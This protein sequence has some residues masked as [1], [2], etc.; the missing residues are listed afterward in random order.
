TEIPEEIQISGVISIREHQ[1]T[2]A[3]D[4]RAK[5]YRVRVEINK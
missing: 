2:L 1:T 5:G 4:A 3:A